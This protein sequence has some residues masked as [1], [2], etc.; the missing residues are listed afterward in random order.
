MVQEVDQGATPRDASTVLLVRDG[1]RGIEVWML[2]R[3]AVLAFA[4]RAWVFP[5]GAVLES[6]ALLPT[7]PVSDP[8]HRAALLGV[9]PLRAA[10]LHE[11]AVRET[12]EE[13]GVAL[14]RVEE[15]RSAVRWSEADRHDLLGGATSLVGLLER[16]GAVIDAEHLVPWDRWLTPAWSPRRYDTWFFIVDARR[17]PEPTH[18]PGGEADE[19]GWVVPHDML[20]RWGDD[21]QALL[22]PTVACLERLAAAPSVDAVLTPPQVALVRRSG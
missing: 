7:W 19:S 11:A 9:E 8:A 2:R 12:F 13:C 16:D 15:D 1:D 5:G 14:A 20:R 21:R 3:I 17:W 22:P 6:S 18:V 10:A 4:P